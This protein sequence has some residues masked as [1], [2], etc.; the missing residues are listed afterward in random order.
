[1]KKLF[2]FALPFLLLFASCTSSDS[3]ITSRYVSNQGR[4][5]PVAD[6]LGGISGTVE[7]FD[8]LYAVAPSTADKYQLAKANGNL[9]WCYFFVVLAVISLGLGIILTSKGGSGWIMVVAGTVAVIMCWCSAG[10]INSAASKEAE[11]PKT[12]Y[13]S[14]M[15]ADGNLKVFWNANLSK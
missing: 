15:K 11:I 8:S 3:A 5:I 12:T 14:L 10:T 1:M 9:F 4:W 6:S 2:L 13:D 7:V